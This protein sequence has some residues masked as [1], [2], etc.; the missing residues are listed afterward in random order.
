ME[1]VT[2]RSPLDMLV[3]SPELLAV[4]L[5]TYIPFILCF[6]HAKSRGEDYMLL[7]F[8]TFLGASVVDPVRCPHQQFS[9]WVL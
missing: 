9:L 3:K 1:W 2:L 5:A 8:V 4:E 6:F 7:F